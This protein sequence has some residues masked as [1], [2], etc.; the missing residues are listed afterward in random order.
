[1]VL[2]F[3]PAN[4]RLSV[5]ICG[6]FKQLFVKVGGVVPGKAA[7]NGC[8]CAPAEVFPFGLI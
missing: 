7:F 3:F 2:S 6:C 5:F 4:L 8:P 1:M